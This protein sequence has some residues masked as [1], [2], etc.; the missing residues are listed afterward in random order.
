MSLPDPTALKVDGFRM[1]PADKNRT[2][3]TPEG[4]R[5]FLERE[6]TL[7]SGRP[8]NDSWTLG[9]PLPMET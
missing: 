5:L 1:T 2:P 6:S 8:N 4:H 3:T 7:L 9:T